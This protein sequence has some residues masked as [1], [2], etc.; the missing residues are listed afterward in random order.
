MF[1]I[2]SIPHKYTKAITRGIIS[3]S[4]NA[5]ENSWEEIIVM[6]GSTFITEVPSCARGQIFHSIITTISV[7]L[8]TNW[9][10]FFIFSNYMAERA[11]D[12]WN[13]HVHIIYKRRYRAKINV[14]DRHYSPNFIPFLYFFFVESY[15]CIH[16]DK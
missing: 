13:P 11:M 14:Y 3:L 5:Q 4:T 9:N 1:P 2:H 8:R 16:K 12:E 6:H 15:E 10:N 7:N